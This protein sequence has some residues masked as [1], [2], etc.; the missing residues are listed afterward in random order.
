MFT[1]QRKCKYHTLYKCQG[2]AFYAV[3]EVIVLA[4]GLNCPSN[5]CA[6]QIQLKKILIKLTIE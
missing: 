1:L 6:V 5:R 3:S 2:K 4:A